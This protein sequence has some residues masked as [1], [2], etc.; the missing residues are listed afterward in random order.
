MAKTTSPPPKD[1]STQ[2]N[3]SDTTVPNVYTGIS[4]YQMFA[5]TSYMI[6]YDNGTTVLMDPPVAD[7]ANYVSPDINYTNWAY[8]G[9]K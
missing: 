6:V 1:T 4:Y 5:N 3:S 9:S 8:G 2:T 7:L